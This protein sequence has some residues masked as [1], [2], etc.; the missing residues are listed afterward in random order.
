[1]LEEHINVAA[2]REHP[3][4]AIGD[5]GTLLR[6]I[7]LFPQP[8]VDEPGRDHLG[9]LEFVRFR[10]AQ[11]DPVLLEQPVDLIIQPG[12]IAELERAADILGQLLDECR[13]RRQSALIFGGNWNS[14]GPRR[15]A[16]RSGSI[17]LKNTS[18]N[19]DS[20]KRRMCVIR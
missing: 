6:R 5:L 9:N 1:M 3:P 13:Q 8:N 15:R 11:R 2:S 12:L 4:H 14:T 7:I 16:A 10:Q 20:C 17:A 18:V 19:S